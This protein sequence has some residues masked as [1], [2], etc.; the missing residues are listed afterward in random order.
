[1]AAFR[2]RRDVGEAM[3]V[4]KEAAARREAEIEEDLRTAGRPPQDEPPPGV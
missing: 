3:S 2:A 4:A 1:V